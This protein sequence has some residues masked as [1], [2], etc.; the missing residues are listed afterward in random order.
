MTIFRN[1]YAELLITAYAIE[2]I[3]SG[4]CFCHAAV[5]PA[6]KNYTAFQY[7]DYSSN[8]WISSNFVGNEY[9]NF[10][11]K[12]KNNSANA[13][14]NLIRSTDCQCNARIVRYHRYNLGF[15][16]NRMG[17]WAPILLS[18]TKV[19]DSFP[20]NCCKDR[21]LSFKRFLNWMDF[22][23]QEWS[24]DYWRSWLQSLQGDFVHCWR[25]HRQ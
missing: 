6:C 17:V 13:F 12:I 3:W 1:R 22:S 4:S 19:W 10:Q 20:S 15:A 18:G 2:Q 25:C 16:Y 24:I 8:D 21:A 5:I 11:T 7:Q 14:G 23:N 9:D